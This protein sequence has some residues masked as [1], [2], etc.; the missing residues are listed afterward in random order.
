MM[1]TRWASAENPRGEVGQGDQTHGGR[2]G[3]PSVPLLAG[4]T[5]VLAEEG[6]GVA[7]TV[8]RIWLTIEN[9]TPELLRGV[10]VDFFWDGAKTPAVSAPLGD[11]FGVGLGRTVPFECAVFSNAEGRSFCA[12]VPMP[13]QNGMRLT[14][15]NETQKDI[16][17]LFYDVNY[18]VGDAHDE[19][20]GYFHAHFRRE[21]PTTCAVTTNC[22]RALRG[23]ANFWA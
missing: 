22:C 10:R 23:G 1:Q 8:R 15:T 20:T 9:R 13:F 18:T 21:N 19:T 17:L 12:I 5:H 7:G 6:M 14:I 3:R 2:K 16:A 4:Q 11:F